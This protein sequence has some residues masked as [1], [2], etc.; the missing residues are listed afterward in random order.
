LASTRSA[1][2]DSIEVAYQRLS[3]EYHIEGNVLRQDLLELVENL[4]NQGILIRDKNP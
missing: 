3:D 4:I 1:T 2:S